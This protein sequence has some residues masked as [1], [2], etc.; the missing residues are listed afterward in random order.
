M[1]LDTLQ[2]RESYA[3]GI[4]FGNQMQHMVDM[5]DLD[6][7]LAGLRVMLERKQPEI[8]VEEF[9]T[10]VQQFDTKLQAKAQTNFQAVADQN[11][12]TGLEFL[13][14]NKSEKGW[15]ATES[16]LQY[17]AIFEG[18]G[19]SP[20]ATDLV[21]VHYEGTLLDGN[22]FDSSYK[23]GEP[24]QFPLNQVIKGWTEGL[25]LMK[26]GGIF[27]FVIPSE[28]AYGLQGNQVIPPNAVLKFR[29]ELLEIVG[30]G[31]EN[32]VEFQA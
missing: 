21:K 29:V 20:A 24:A 4:N 25:Q 1:K 12:Q 5:V 22:V 3:V 19:A 18:E 30:A 32:A 2:K 15:Q 7:L 8:S 31:V 26:V 9:Q 28:L 13:E 14:K 27:D 6:A 23:R 16:G 17:K 11:L 10:L